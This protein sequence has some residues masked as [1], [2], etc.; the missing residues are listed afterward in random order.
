MLFYIKLYI[1]F[2]D[3][4]LSNKNDVNA[5][6]PA[7][8]GTQPLYK[9]CAVYLLIVILNKYIILSNENVPRYVIV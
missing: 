5:P 9:P 7:P 3:R 4:C 2:L 6:I 1:Y 8:T